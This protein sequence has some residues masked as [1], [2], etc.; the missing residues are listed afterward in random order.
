[1]STN[2]NLSL[3][4]SIWLYIGPNGPDAVSGLLGM[5]AGTVRCA[6]EL[7]AGYSGADVLVR[8]FPDGVL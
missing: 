1:M 8:E 5:S 6:E 3:H 2:P 7:P 4:R